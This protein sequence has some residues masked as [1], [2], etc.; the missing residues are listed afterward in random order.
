MTVHFVN[1]E[2]NEMLKVSG[3]EEVREYLGGTEYGQ[4]RC[5]VLT[6]QDGHQQPYPVSKYALYKVEQEV[7]T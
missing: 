5:W 6:M 2:Q 3:L 1:T 7:T 4:K